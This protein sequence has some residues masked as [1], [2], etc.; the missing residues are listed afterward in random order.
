MA[1]WVYKQVL[2][3][4]VSVTYAH[5]V[6]V[7][8]SSQKLVSIQ[9]C[10]QRVNFLSNAFESISNASHRTRNKLHYDVNLGGSIGLRREET[11]QN[12]NNIWMLHFAHN[13]Q[14]S[15]LVLLVNHDFLNANH[16]LRFFDRCTVHFT[17]SSSCNSYF[18]LK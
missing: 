13:L 1:S 18:I 4:D 11:V 12:L 8:D 17:E 2:W 15:A 9:L 5:C 10:Q 16:Q 3:L 6:K 14:L 7:V